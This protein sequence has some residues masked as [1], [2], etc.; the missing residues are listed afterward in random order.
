MTRIAIEV[1]KSEGNR[2]ALSAV[3]ARW[4]ARRDAGLTAAERDELQAWI[5]T[6]R[7]NAE[8]FRAADTDATELDWPL[9]TGAME[10]ILAGLEERRA[11]RGQRRRLVGA[12]TVGMLA[13]TLT[14]FLSNVG[15][16]S[17]ILR[18]LLWSCAPR[19]HARCPTAR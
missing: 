15:S 4:V 10:R 12:L 5:R 3:A 8:A 14:V 11:R 18:Q 16:R 19:K 7:R 1:M 13:I 6:D 2:D 17:A 9:H